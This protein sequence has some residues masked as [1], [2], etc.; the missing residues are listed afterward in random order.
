MFFS[1]EPNYWGSLTHL[2]G[3]VAVQCQ[4]PVFW[5]WEIHTF[6]FKML[7][8]SSG[9]ENELFLHLF[10]LQNYKSVKTSFVFSWIGSNVLNISMFILL[11]AKMFLLDLLFISANLL[12]F[13]SFLP[14]TLEVVQRI[15]M[16][17]GSIK[18][19]AINDKKCISW[20]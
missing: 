12:G 9:N 2:Q 14:A 18:T 3:C 6:F 13:F 19:T 8:L 1:G 4:L 10:K 15:V 20:I 17:Q 5:L 11:N 16:V 7:L